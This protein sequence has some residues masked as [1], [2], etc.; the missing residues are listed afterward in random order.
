MN[1]H[2]H[3]NEFDLFGQLYRQR[4]LW[5]SRIETDITS[6]SIAWF[7]AMICEDVDE[8]KPSDPQKQDEQE[9]M[10]SPL[11]LI[12]RANE[13]A[14]QAASNSQTNVSTPQNK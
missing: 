11:A 8:S 13:L 7:H 14:Q 3:L 12:V 4:N 5:Q 6:V 10:A 2:L 9:Q 1:D